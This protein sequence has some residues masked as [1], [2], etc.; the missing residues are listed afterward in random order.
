MYSVMPRSKLFTAYII[1]F[2]KLLFKF[3]PY[4]LANLQVESIIH[5]SDI[6]NR[7]TDMCIYCNYNIAHWVKLADSAVER[8]TC[9]RTV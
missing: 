7:S 2:S 5:I 6:S 1:L 8:P 9:L 3:A 4:V